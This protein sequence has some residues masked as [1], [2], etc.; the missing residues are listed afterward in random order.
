M[1]PAKLTNAVSIDGVR[2]IDGDASSRDFRSQ[3]TS[4]FSKFPTRHTLPQT[5]AT[6]EYSGRLARG[7]KIYRVLT[8]S[9]LPN[10]VLFARRADHVLDQPPITDDAFLDAH[11]LADKLHRILVDQVAR[12]VPLDEKQSFALTYLI[13]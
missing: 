9:F 1:A 6:R 11:P 5:G 10:P 13:T 7:Y 4:P 2:I 12:V 3:K 8:L